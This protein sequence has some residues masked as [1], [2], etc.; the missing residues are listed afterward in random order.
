MISTSRTSDFQIS[1]SAISSHKN[2]QVL[3]TFWCWHNSLN[4]LKGSSLGK[5]VTYAKHQRTYMKNYLLDGRCSFQT[6]QQ[7][8]WLFSDIPKVV[9]TS[10]VV[11]SLAETAK[12]NCLTVNKYL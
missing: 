6:T 5:E 11:Y 1:G 12:T 7:K 2:I 8:E 9:S 4:T 3:E 10:A